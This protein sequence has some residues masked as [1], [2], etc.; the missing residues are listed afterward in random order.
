MTQLKG[1]AKRLIISSM[2]SNGSPHSVCDI[3]RFSISRPFHQNCAC[4]QNKKAEQK[5]SADGAAAASA[6]STAASAASFG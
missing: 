1:L 5:P 4:K 6:A 2:L 3:K